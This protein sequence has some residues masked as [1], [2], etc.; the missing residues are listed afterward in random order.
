MADPK[1][2]LAQ[3]IRAKYPDA[4]KDM[5]DVD[6]ENSVL[7][8][9]P[10]YSDFPRTQQHGSGGTWEPETF[11]QKVDRWLSPSEES[12]NSEAWGNF[13]KGIVAAPMQAIHHP[14][15]TFGPLVQ[16]VSQM[17]P[18]PELV[19]QAVGM[20]ESAEKYPNYTLGNLVGGELTGEMLRKVPLPGPNPSPAVEPS[21]SAEGLY[22]KQADAFSS[23]LS[24]VP[25]HDLPAISNSSLPLLKE[26]LADLGGTPDVF[27]GREGLT[28]AK[29][30]TDH[31][32]QLQEAKI[33]PLIDTVRNTPVD[34]QLFKMTPDLAQH[35]DPSE[36][37]TYGDIDAIRKEANKQRARGNYDMKPVSKQIA[38]PESVVD[39]IN[40][41]DQARMLLYKAVA[42]RTGIDVRPMT[43]QESNLITLSDAMNKSHEATSQAKAIWE[44]T[45]MWEK[46]PLA[47]LAVGARGPSAFLSESTMKAGR[48]ISPLY[49]FNRAMRLAFADVEPQAA[50]TTI[51]PT[52][53][54]VWMDQQLSQPAPLGLPPRTIEIEPRQYPQLPASSAA[55]NFGQ[56]E[57][58][59][60]PFLSQPLQLPAESSAPI[61]TP[62]PKLSWAD[63][64][65]QKA[66]KSPR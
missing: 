36:T 50:T 18:T 37:V 47:R 7:A 39:A 19:N 28:W 6:L 49:E 46:V 58:R 52:A 24:K 57:I 13:A 29:A 22:S 63:M 43:H 3:A 21:V 5:S 8:K 9:Y 14:I 44:T 48:T 1:Q 61:I 42:D 16:S 64:L 62:P 51:S 59:G 60:S 27:H 56:T 20:K 40:T 11:G 32:V 34:P 25:G 38:A 31:A 15:Q 23:V 54:H 26:S 33:K 66:G 53:E 12:S 4:Y 55:Y 2:T 41:A 35:F 17:W 10:E 65:R 45:P 30:V